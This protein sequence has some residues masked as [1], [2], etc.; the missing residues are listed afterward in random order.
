MKQVLETAVVLRA[1]VC[2]TDCFVALG[3]CSVPCRFI[4]WDR[5]L[6]NDFSGH[7]FC[8]S[9]YEAQICRHA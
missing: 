2:L 8:F 9:L 4:L 5:P 3:L 7:R 1:R 6:G